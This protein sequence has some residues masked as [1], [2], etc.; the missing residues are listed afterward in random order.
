M[1]VFVFGMV[2][3]IIAFM[4]EELNTRG[5]LI[6]AYMVGSIIITDLMV[7]V[8]ILFLLIGVVVAVLR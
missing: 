7:I 6:D 1:I 8:I 5:I 2:G 3:I 4:L